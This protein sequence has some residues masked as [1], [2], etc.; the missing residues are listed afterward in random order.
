M[1]VVKKQ[2]VGQYART[3]TDDTKSVRQL[4]TIQGQYSWLHVSRGRD[5]LEQRERSS[6][7]LAFQLMSNQKDRLHSSI[8]MI[9]YKRVG[10]VADIGGCHEEHCITKYKRI[11]RQK[12]WDDPKSS[13]R[14][15]GG[16]HFI[17]RDVQVEAR[18]RNQSFNYRRPKLK[19]SYDL[20]LKP[21]ALFTVFLACSTRPLPI[22]NQI[23]KLT[24]SLD[25]RLGLW[26]GLTASAR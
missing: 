21:K 20:L 26:L 22:T 18:W 15:Q 3:S 12:L 11:E 23:N 17:M 14:L 16:Q 25:K 10:P 13:R 24:T 1:G 2:H 8:S 9:W 7:G 6:L 5:A 4:Y 19:A